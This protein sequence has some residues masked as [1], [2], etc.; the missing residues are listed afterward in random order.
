V[1]GLRRCLLKW[2]LNNFSPLTGSSRHYTG[3]LKT[4]LVWDDIGIDEILMSKGIHGM[5]SIIDNLNFREFGP[6]SS[7]EVAVAV[8]VVVL[9]VFFLRS[10]K[11]RESLKSVIKA[12]FAAKLIV[13]YLI[14]IVYSLIPLGIFYYFGLWRHSLIKDASFWLIFS[15]LPTLMTVRKADGQY[16]KNILYDNLKFSIVIEFIVGLHTFHIF[17]EIIMT[18]FALFIGGIIAVSGRDPKHKVVNALFT[19]LAQI[20][21]IVILLTAIYSFAADIK[22]N[23]TLDKFEEFSLPILLGIWII[24]L[25]YLLYIYMAYENIYTSMKFS[26]KNQEL[27][28]FAKV[29]AFFHFKFN[30]A[31]LKRWSQSLYITEINK[32]Q[33]ILISLLDLERLELV[34]RDPQEI[35]TAQGWS[36]YRAK[37]FLQNDGILTNHY[38][39][40]YDSE[41]QAISDYVKLGEEI[42]DNDIAY[43]VTGNQTIAK[44]LKLVVNINVINKEDVAKDRFIACAKSLTEAALKEPMDIEVAIA[45]MKEEDIS[46]EF[47]NRIISLSKFNHLNRVGSYTLTYTIRQ[48]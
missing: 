8:C 42:I 9:L 6:F 23:I 39:R 21:G 38:K 1:V 35:D 36:P 34:E 27:Y 30:T 4:V 40:C 29:H 31:S 33:D 28:K 37:N 19:R 18:L 22:E 43:Y 10:A 13:L 24:P 46:K 17:V 11:I 20:I 41:W 26:I 25:L 48:L 45:I 47:Q 12:F 15:A 7:R 2:E 3:N 32:K 5:K 44:C 14:I 16:F